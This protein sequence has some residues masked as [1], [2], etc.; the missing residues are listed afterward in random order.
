MVMTKWYKLVIS[1]GRYDCLFMLYRLRFL[2]TLS[3]FLLRS[4]PV[5]NRACWTHWGE[6]SSQLR[7]VF[8]S[9]KKES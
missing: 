5:L 9:Y 1:C 6:L 7:K 3:G 8:P 4:H 2:P